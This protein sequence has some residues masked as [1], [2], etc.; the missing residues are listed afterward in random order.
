MENAKQQHPVEYTLLQLSGNESKPVNGGIARYMPTLRREIA[1]Q[2][3][4]ELWQEM[5]LEGEPLIF[6]SPMQRQRL[7]LEHHPLLLKQ[8]VDNDKQRK[9][10]ALGQLQSWE[11]LVAPAYAQG[12]AVVGE[13]GI[14]LKSDMQRPADIGERGTVPAAPYSWICYTFKRDWKALSVYFYDS[15]NSDSLT[16][17]AIP[18]GRQDEWLAFLK[19]LSDLYDAIWRRECRGCI[20]IIGG[21]DELADVIRKASFDDVVLPEETLEHVAAQRHIFDKQMLQRYEA[22]R[23]PRLRK[24]L[25]IGPPGTGKTTLLKAEGAYHAKQ[26]GFVCYVCAPSSGRSNSPWQQLTKA[27]HMAVESQLPTLILVEEFEMF[28]SNPPELQLILDTLDGVATPDNPAGTLL[29]ATS[30][31]PE[32]IDQRLRDRPGRIDAL[33]EIGLVEDNELAIRFLKHFLGPTYREEEHAPVAS[34]FL[35]QSGSHFREVCIAGTMHALEQGRTDVSSD[36][37]LWAHETI[38]TGRAIAAEVDRFIPTSTQ[39]RGGYFGRKH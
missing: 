28:V 34:Q 11:L 27:L 37:L 8:L 10:S 38:L 12:I 19:L 36:D 2:A 7:Q 29:L 5:K 33:I 30:Y 26:G 18:G 32:K 17:T 16:L 35:K 39:K 6:V 23:M 3:L 14:L 1:A 21:S 9:K 22:L 20:E 15:D 31:D 25:L 4:K 13:V 24:V